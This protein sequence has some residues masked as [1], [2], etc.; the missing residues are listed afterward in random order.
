MP[1]LTQR[2]EQLLAALTGTFERTWV[3]AQRG[4]LTGPEAVET[5]STFL[6]QLA[7]KGLAEKGGSRLDTKWRRTQADNGRS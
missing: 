3:V 5:A 1:S 4:G 2:E 7:K 6:T